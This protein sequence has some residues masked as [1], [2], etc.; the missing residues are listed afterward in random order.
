MEHAY[1][2]P[3]IKGVQAGREFF[4][5]MCPLRIIPKI[6]LYDEEELGPEFRAQR[7]LNRSRVPDI[8]RYIVGNQED[9]CFSAIT[10]SIDGDVEFAAV[11]GTTNQ[12]GSLKIPMTARFI[13]NDG[14]HRRAAIEMALNE[15]PK[16]GSETIAVV[17]FHDNGL[18]RSQQMFAD[19]NRTAVRPSAS[20]GVLY[21]HR[22]EVANVT[23]QVVFKS[24]FFR[25]LVELERTTLALRS[26][27]LFT[28]SAL[29]SANMELVGD[30]EFEEY[31]EVVECVT[32][33]WEE[34]AK[35]IPEWTL[36]HQSRMTS[37]EVRQDFLHSHSLVLQA[38]G[39]VGGTLL[40]LHPEGWNE[41]LAEIAEIDWSR[42]NNEWEG[43]AVYAGKVV[44]SR[45]NVLLVSNL[46]K[47][48][49]GLPLSAGETSEEAKF[50]EGKNG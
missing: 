32:Q 14:Q 29:H 25:H 45:Q 12:M 50:K 46:V 8:A 3:A 28:L 19:L 40:R 39:R 35:H 33:Y 43:R 11:E 47:Q 15:E 7:T 34:V 48:K 18:E 16:L 30:L 26:R 23:R 36:V 31:D 37:G 24:D 27:K 20:I 44:N 13:I 49:M 2:F 10:A 17:F 38:L 1:V 21:D 5:S 41:L 4:V 6:F 9:Y 22:D 42:G